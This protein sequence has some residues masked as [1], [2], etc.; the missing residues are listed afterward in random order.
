MATHPSASMFLLGGD[1]PVLRIGYGA[2]RLV[3]RDLWGPYEDREGGIG[4]LRRVVEA[5]VTV[6]DTADAYGPHSN[7]LLI[8]DALAPYPRDLVIATK[9]GLVRGGP[10]LD[11][12]TAVGN[13]EYLRQSAHMSLQRLGLDR[14]DLYYLHS[15]AA[16]DASF[17]DQVGTLAELRNQGSSVT[18]ACQTSPWSSCGQRRRSRRLLRSPPTTTS[19]A[20]ASRALLDAALASGAA[21]VP[22]Q[23]VSL[24][25][26]GDAIDTFGPEHLREVLGS[27]AATHEATIP[28]ISLAWLLAIAPGVLPIPATTS[29]S[30]LR[31]NLAALDLELT[32]DEL[33]SIDALAAR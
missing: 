29:V 17:E 16:T 30:H 23:P 26:P 6:I 24:S 22:W 1:L 28:Q 13:P 33:A 10:G 19:P 32:A 14:I 2:M 20:A 4:I 25:A 15:A 31:E 18:S 7:E 21:F 3:G 9:G 5:G 12:I 8:R 11:H 27:V